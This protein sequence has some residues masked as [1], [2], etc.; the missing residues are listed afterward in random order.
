MSDEPISSTDDYDLLF[1]TLSQRCG[2]IALFALSGRP[3]ELMTVED[4]AVDVSRIGDVGGEP[5]PPHTDEDW[6]WGR[7]HHE[8]LPRLDDAGVLAYDHEIGVVT[9]VDHTQVDRLVSL[10]RELTDVDNRE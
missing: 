1:T 8:T 7:L 6:L 4:L 2:R 9:D 10:V 5:L 3:D